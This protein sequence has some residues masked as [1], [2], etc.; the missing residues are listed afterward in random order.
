MC[1]VVWGDEDGVTKMRWREWG[2][3]DGAAR[4]WGDEGVRWRRWGDEDGV[5]RMGCASD[6]RV[7]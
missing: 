4:V 1:D 7:M 3:E 6:V 5:T 2:G